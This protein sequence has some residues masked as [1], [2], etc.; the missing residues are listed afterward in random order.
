MQSP[1]R[2]C[3][4]LG[5]NSPCG[6]LHKDFQQGFMGSR[7]DRVGPLDPLNSQGAVLAGL[8]L[9]L[10]F[11]LQFDDKQ[12]SGDILSL[13]QLR[14]GQLLLHYFHLRDYSYVISLI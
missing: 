3:H 7:H 9:E 6:D 12:V 2:I 4:I 1:T 14:P 11:R 8:E 13:D 5:V 10:L